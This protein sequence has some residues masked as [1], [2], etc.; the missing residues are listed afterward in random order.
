MSR[1]PYWEAVWVETETY[2]PGGG[3]TKTGDLDL[4]RLHLPEQH[5]VCLHHLSSN[6]RGIPEGTADK[7]TCAGLD[8]SETCTC[9]V[10]I[11][12]SV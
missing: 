12:T 9:A 1:C 11:S 10:R 7:I 8:I 4:P 6:V 5:H 2:A 3:C